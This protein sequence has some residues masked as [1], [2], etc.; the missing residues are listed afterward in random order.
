MFNRGE[1][2]IYFAFALGMAFNLASIYIGNPYIIS[3][4]LIPVAAIT[5]IKWMN[6][7]IP[8]IVLVSVIAANPSNLNTPVA[9]NLIFALFFGF[10][11]L[12]NISRLPSWL[13]LV[14]FFAFISI[15]GSVVDWGTT[16]DVFTQFA[17]ICNYVIGPFFL[18]PLIY[19]RLQ[20]EVDAYLLLKAFVFSL[21]VPSVSLM[22]LARIL[23]TP[24]IGPN[25]SAFGSFVNIS[26]Y[27]LGNVDFQ[28]TRT[29]AGILLSVL[30]CASFSI[31]ICSGAKIMRLLAFVALGVAIFLLLVTGSVGSSWPQC[32]ALRYCWLLHSDIYRLKEVW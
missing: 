29:Q 32:V 2:H 14:L 22:L 19:F 13:H 17:A 21:I 10:L 4:I 18:I 31:I 8:W 30:I 23:G 5:A 25:F 6:K 26:I 27:H 28:M 20:K 1:K 16:A 7:P 12:R 15:I 24:V 9:L 11:R 3:L